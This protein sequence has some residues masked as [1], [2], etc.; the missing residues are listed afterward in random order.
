MKRESPDI[1]RSAQH[2]VVKAV[3]RLDAD[4]AARR[5]EEKG[6]AWGRHLAIEAIASGVAID[7][8]LLGPGLEGDEEG[9]R[10]ATAVIRTGAQVVR[11]A[12]ALLDAIAAGAGDQG[13]LLVV[14]R[15]AVSLG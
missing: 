9:G 8:A 2:P 10:I 13:V 3:R 7:T 15:R 4:A 6:I 11:V 14:R 5:R 1:V 12:P